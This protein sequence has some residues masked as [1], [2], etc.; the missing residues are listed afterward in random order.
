MCYLLSFTDDPQSLNGSRPLGKNFYSFD[1]VLQAFS[2]ISY[3]SF[4][5]QLAIMSIAASGL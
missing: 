2:K 5:Q 3:L 4:R 1:L